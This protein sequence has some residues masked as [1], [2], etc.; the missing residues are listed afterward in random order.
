MTGYLFVDNYSVEQI[1]EAAF[2]AGKEQPDVE[3]KDKDQSLLADDAL[4]ATNHRIVLT[5][6]FANAE[7]NKTEP[8]PEE[9]KAPD[10]SKDLLWLWI[11]SGIVG[12]VILLV[13]VVYLIKKFG[14]KHSNSSKKTFKSKK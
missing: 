9:E 10:K 11:S 8:E 1:D 6:E 5:E 7:E 13:L 4:A 3:E 14:K 12:G 2:I